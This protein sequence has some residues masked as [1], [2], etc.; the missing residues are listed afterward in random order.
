MLNPPERQVNVTRMMI[1]SL[2]PFL[3]IY[4]GW[5]IQR[6]WVLSGISMIITGTGIGAS[7][8]LSQEAQM[9][10]EG[11]VAA[12]FMILNIV[13]ACLMVRYFAKRYNGEMII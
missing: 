9:Y 6:F 13:I 4:A 11:E 10:N 7:W 2:I 3:S 12:V 1:Y 5:R 8:Y